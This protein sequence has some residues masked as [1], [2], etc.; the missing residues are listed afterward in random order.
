MSRSPS[1]PSSSPGTIRAQLAAGYARDGYWSDEVLWDWVTRNARAR[2]NA[3]ALKTWGGVIT[4]AELTQRALACAA[5]LR[6]LG[7]SKGDVVAVQ[8]PNIPE[9]VV[10]YLAITRLGAV[11]QTMHMPYRAADIEV[12]LAH[13]GAK[14]M[15]CMSKSGDFVGAETCL[16]LR[17]R[18]PQLRAVIAVGAAAP[19]SAHAFDS[20]QQAAMADTLGHAH[21][22]S[23]A[24]DFLLLYTSG[25]TASPKGVPHAYRDFLANAR[26]SARELSVEA[27]DVLLPVA[28]FTHLYGLFAVN[29]ALASGACVALLPAFTPPE[30]ARALRELKPTIAFTAPAH[31]AACLNAKLF[32][33]IDLSHMKYVQIS[34]SAVPPALARALEPMLTGGRV[35]QLWGMTE[36]QAGAYTRLTDS[37]AVR[38]ETTGRASPGTDLRVVDGDG[39]VLAMTTA[40]DTVSVP[41]A[42]AN[43]DRTTGAALASTEGELQMR[44]PSLFEGYRNNAAATAES[45]T[46]DGWFR[47]G[48]LAVIDADGNT[49]L[50]GR[51]KDIINRGGV[52]FNPLDIEALLQKHPAIAEVAIAP[53]PDALL[54]ERACC[55]AVLKAGA[56]LDLEGVRAY[57]EALGVNKIKWPE[58]FECVTAMPLTPTRKIIKSALIA[59]LYATESTA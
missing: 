33:G 14:A 57:L 59:Q 58:R 54:G 5:G 7:I 32:D 27:H 18:L 42:G 1:K 50:T 46:P 38:A 31:I 43:S 15:V 22:L 9:F 13:S 36:L 37:E 6:A 52:K 53:L 29:M 51:V 10:A 21:G 23:G 35:M 44:G 56:A 55:F 11:M 41:R 4:Y 48:D 26:L 16:A 3:P 49:R 24:D 40:S 34:G 19:D 25:T 20:L 45:F 2:G 8:L 17:A 28:P 30:L 12:L 39:A 47:T